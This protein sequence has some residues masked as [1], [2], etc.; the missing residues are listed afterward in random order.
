MRRRQPTSNAGIY[1]DVS[2]PRAVDLLV[3]ELAAPVGVRSLPALALSPLVVKRS[4]I[5]RMAGIGTAARRH[6]G[7][8]KTVSEEHIKQV[9][10]EHQLLFADCEDASATRAKSK[11]LLDDIMGK[12][13][14][15]VQHQLKF[16]RSS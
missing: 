6:G 7:T 1:V 2:S 4:L 13:M 5:G 16:A 8:K 9:R 3:A 11:R 14:L 10:V 15:D 12:V